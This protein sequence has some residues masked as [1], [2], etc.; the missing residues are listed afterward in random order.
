M[1]IIICSLAAAVQLATSSCPTSCILNCL[2]AGVGIRQDQTAPT[3]RFLKYSASHRHLEILTIV[4]MI[5]LLESLTLRKKTYYPLVQTIFDVDW[6]RP[7]IASCLIGCWLT[8][9]LNHFFGRRGT[10]FWCGIFCTFSVIGSALA[11]TWPQLFVRRMSSRHVVFFSV[12]IFMLL[13]MPPPSWI[14]DG[15]QSLYFTCL[16]CGKRAS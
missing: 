1:T 11:Q 6:D 8:D 5:G 2:S 4:V 7:Y 3:C 16:C 15:P 12:L 9:P 13:G 14:G 10:L